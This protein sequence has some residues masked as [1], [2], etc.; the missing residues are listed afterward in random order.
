MLPNL[1]ALRLGPVRRVQAL[2]PNGKPVGMYATDSDDEE[3][4]EEQMEEEEPEPEG[5]P[6]RPLPGGYAGAVQYYDAL[7]SENF[8]SHAE[9][10]YQSL[11]A[12]IRGMYVAEN[13]TYG[14]AVD[15]LF[16]DL[17]NFKV[18]YDQAAIGIQLHLG[19]MLRMLAFDTP[20]I[21]EEA[22]RLIP[23]LFVDLIMGDSA[24]EDES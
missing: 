4:A 15:G 11:R 14:D 8:D 23:T 7:Q 16:Q 18:H 3:E 19:V 22:M 2:P 1:S 6:A 17:Q 21:Q 20:Q 10:A 9:Q 5:I 24:Y 13:Q 12:I